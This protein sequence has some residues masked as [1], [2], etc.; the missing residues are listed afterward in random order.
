MEVK[1]NIWLEKSGQV[2]LSHWR[3]ELLEA[4]DA[5]GSIS[6]AARQLQVPY[7]RAWE[8]I[9][10]MEK[11]LGEPLVKTSAGGAGGGGATLTQAGRHLITQFRKFMHGFE[12]LLQRRYQE[13][14]AWPMHP[15]PEAY[16]APATKRSKATPRKT[17]ARKTKPQR[18]ST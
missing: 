2:V 11:G 5:T 4:I 7:R 17:L 1:F 14:F 3:M 10:E 16:N 13:L 9:H 12:T 15:A 8:K 6:A 18:R